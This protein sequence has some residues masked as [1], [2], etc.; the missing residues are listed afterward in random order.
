MGAR[1][2]Y[3]EATV[4][5]GTSIVG[6]YRRK[7]RAFSKERPFKAKKMNRQPGT[8]RTGRPFPDAIRLAVWQRALGV[9]G[10]SLAEWRQDVCG[11]YIRWDSYGV[12][13]NKGFGWEIDHVNPISNGGSDLL[14]NLQ[15]LQWENNRSKGDKIGQFICAIKY[16]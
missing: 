6:R 9:P 4:L 15:A 11:A 12:T 10:R 14:E 8:D 2:D 5:L 1:R 16:A 3:V 13:K 7:A